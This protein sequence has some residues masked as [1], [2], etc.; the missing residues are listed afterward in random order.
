MQNDAFLDLVRKNRRDATEWLVSEM[1]DR[2]WR[3][4]CRCLGQ[5]AE[6]GVQEVF[7]EIHRSL[8][9]FRGDASVLTWCYRIA[10]NT[11]L[12]QQ[13]KQK[14]NAHFR[15]LDE[16]DP[17]IKAETVS[18]FQDTPFTRLRKKELRARVQ[19]ALEQLEEIH[20]T[21]LTLR[22]FENLSYREIAEALGVPPG[23]VKSRMA[24]ASA[25]LAEKLQSTMKEDEDGR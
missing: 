15:P 12:D 19:G 5:E 11:L 9:R 25:R 4:A 2:I 18:G 13:K 8:P 14:R 20:R 1:G 10:M 16:S 24:A 22:S 7:R 17:D 23:T 21:V 6:D 3:L